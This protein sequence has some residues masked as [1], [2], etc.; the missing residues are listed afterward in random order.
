[1]DLDQKQLAERLLAQT[2]GVGIHH[3]PCSSQHPK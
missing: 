1:M 3:L 2:K